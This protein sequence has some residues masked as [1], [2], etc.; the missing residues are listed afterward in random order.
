MAERN[1]GERRSTAT[2]AEAHEPSSVLPTNRRLYR[3]GFE[4]RTRALNEGKTRNMNAASA[5]GLP[6]WS[7]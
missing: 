4:K 6:V 1:T 5:I 2:L 3:S 7:Q